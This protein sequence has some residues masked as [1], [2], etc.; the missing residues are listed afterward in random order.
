[1]TDAVED[2]LESCAQD[3]VDLDVVERLLKPENLEVSLR[4]VLKHATC[5][6]SGKKKEHYVWLA[7]PDGKRSGKA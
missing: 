4:Y 6:G 1:M 5:R 3:I 2:Y 7:G